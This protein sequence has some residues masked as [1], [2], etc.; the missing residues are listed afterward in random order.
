MFNPDFYPTP[1]NVIE[2]MT[3]GIPLKGKTILEP[4][5]GAGNIVDYCI[6]NGAKVIACE[7]D[8]RLKT[9]VQS[10]CRVLADDFFTITSDKISHVDYIIMN[11]PFSNGA[12][13]LIHAFQIAPPGSKI[14]CLLNTETIKNT[15]SS[16]RKELHSII[17]NYGSHKE[18][19]DCFVDAERKTN[20]HVSMVTL[21][22]QGESY[23]KEFS[24]FFTEEDPEEKQ[25]NG[26]IQY[27]EVR[28]LV[29]RYV[30]AVKLYDEQINVGKRMHTL[31]SNFYGEKLAFTCTNHG[32][33]VLRNEF[34][35]DLQ[36]AGWKYIFDKLNLNKYSTRGLSET[37]NKFVEEQTQYPFTMR[38][39]Y[40][41]IDIVIQTTGQR[42]DKAII[43]VFDRVTERHHE[44]RYNLKGWKTNGHFL[45]GKKFILPYQISPAKEYGYTSDAYNYLNGRFDGI[46]PD[47]EKALCFVTGDVYDDIKT[48]SSSINRNVY[49]EWYESHFFKYKGYK[50]G[51]I[52]FEFIN[53]KVW[54]TFNKNVA[55]IKGYPLFEAKEQTAYQQRQTG[56]S[57]KQEVLFQI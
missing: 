7:K 28:E 45:V 57:F 8:Y 23:E 25:A 24:G 41:M 55:R 39:I 50:N 52:H 30:A 10:K 48:L 49:G 38:N 17:E 36:K 40:H 6:E 18:L 3:G 43:E 22:K 14:I 31:L 13:H 16:T 1:I 4:S 5:A 26:L 54:E 9:I 37:I 32:A 21:E 56:R 15:W 42:M 53:E 44:N 51:N 2:K 47:F 34:K 27:N 35:K 12:D 19:E 20:V 29:N 46:I 33:I 11:P